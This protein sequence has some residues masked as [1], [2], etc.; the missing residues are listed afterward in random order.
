MME[1][2]TRQVLV[3]DDDRSVCETYS[4][5]LARKGYHVQTASTLS[6]MRGQLAH[7]MFDAL[8]LDIFLPDGNS[9]DV[10]EGLRREYPEMAIVLMTAEG[11]VNMA[12]EAMR[13]G[14]DNFLTKPVNLNDLD[15]FL[16]KGLEVSALR[17]ERKALLRQT[18]FEPMFV[19]KSRPW[20]KTMELARLAAENDNAVLIM[21]ET[22]TGK[23][24]LA[25]W[26]HAN[27]A[28][29]KEVFVELNCSSLRGELLASEL[30]GHVKGAFTSAISDKQGL[31]EVAD[32]GTLFLDE[33]GDMDLAVQAQFL[34]VIEEKRFRRVGDVRVRESE[35]RL[36]CA[37]N[38]DLTQQSAEGK[39][40]S[41][42]FFRINVFPIQ[43]PPLR[44]MKEDLPDLA[45]HLART[46]A[47]REIELPANVLNLLLAYSWPGNIRELRNVLERGL[48][49]ARGG[50]LTPEC[51][52]GLQAGA[53]ASAIPVSTLNLKEVERSKIIAA[54][55][56]Y[57]G[58]V[59]MAAKALGIS[60]AT[61]YRRLKELRIE[62]RTSDGSTERASAQ[63]F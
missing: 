42:L 15:V 56:R 31:I 5:F 53:M 59:I 47:G 58:N 14:V 32:R 41:D 28:R 20:S 27:S 2:T 25:K 26:I 30:F 4:K 3:V 36:I 18:R 35:F 23:G 34:K 54:L 9:L 8:V 39:F 12:V 10:I 1:P 50:L 37:T 19:G 60:R 22:G 63:K 45:R 6:E 13:R 38:H 62:R 29:S 44:D 51:F 49:L 43:V 40:R 17:R 16:T 52:P 24:V 21:G 48:I 11:S 61:L 46:I 57:G 7:R 55:E 33:I